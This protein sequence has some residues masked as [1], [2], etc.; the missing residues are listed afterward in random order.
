MAESTVVRTKRD[1]Q[2]VITDGTRTYTVAYEPGDFNLDIPLQAVNMFLDRG[3]IGSTPSI[4]L[5][6]DQPVTFSFSAYERDIYST[7]DATLMD[8]CVV[9]SGSLV[10][11]TWTSTIGTSSDVKTWTVTVTIEGSDFG[12]S[13]RTWTL[14]YSTIRASRSDGDPNVINVSGTCHQLRPT[15]S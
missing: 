2:I 8:L 13:D 1:V 12:G 4:R 7:T 5:G 11:T 15:M 14:P 6:D 10:G 9:P 3:V